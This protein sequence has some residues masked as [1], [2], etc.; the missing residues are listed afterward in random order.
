MSSIPVS[1]PYV[2]PYRPEGGLWFDGQ[3]GYV[4][5]GSDASLD[6]IDE[7]TLAVRFLKRDYTWDGLY[8][9]AWNDTLETGL[10]LSAHSNKSILFRLGNGTTHINFYSI[11]YKYKL[12]TVHFALASFSTTTSEVLLFIDGHTQTNSFT[13]PLD[14]S[15]YHAVVGDVAYGWGAYLNGEIYEVIHLAEALGENDAWALMEGR[16]L[17]T[18]WDCRL[19]LDFRQGHTQ[20]LSGHNN[21]GTRYG[22]TYF[23]P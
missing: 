11:N 9:M 19:W 12:N 14:I 18:E 7:V 8:G 2:L 21:H 13:G 3:T 6:T 5:C 1:G 15:F 16:R 4:D 22:N 17:P 23:V 10:T 20:D